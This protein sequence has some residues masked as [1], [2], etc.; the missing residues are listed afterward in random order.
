MYLRYVTC[1]A[2]LSWGKVSIDFTIFP[3]AM[4]GQAGEII[5]R[6]EEFNNILD[7]SIYWPK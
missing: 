3:W 1:D 2:E 5:P 7:N 6:S 4:L